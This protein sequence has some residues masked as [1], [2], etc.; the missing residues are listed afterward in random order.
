MDIKDVIDYILNHDLDYP[1][2]HQY[3]QKSK[4]FSPHKQ[5]LIIW[6]YFC[7]HIQSNLTC[8]DK[9]TS[10]EVPNFGTFSFMPYN[11]ISL[12]TNDLFM[13]TITNSNNL[14]KD[15]P[16]FQLSSV[17]EKIL[18]KFP[19]ERTKHII[20]IYPGFV[21][22]KEIF[23]KW[24]PFPI[25]KICKVKPIFVSDSIKAITKAIYDLVAEGN[26]II[27]NM[28][29][30]LISFSNGTMNYLYNYDELFRES[31]EEK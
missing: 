20:T 13:S 28:E 10:V 30:I 15:K 18:K 24:N 21:P 19:N 9:L 17:Y 12:K 11:D 23:L 16:I 4:T 27:L 3:Q 5:L 29:F 2:Y 14:N 7:K 31:T 26:N 25:A 6:K 8:K 22:R 1:G